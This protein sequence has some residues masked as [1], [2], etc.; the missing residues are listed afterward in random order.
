MTGVA[1]GSPIGR[2]GLLARR[3][4]A[5][6]RGSGRPRRPRCVRPVRHTAHG[7]GRDR[8]RRAALR[9]PFGGIKRSGYDANSRKSGIR[10]F[11][12]IQTVWIGPATG[13][14][15][16]LPAV[17]E[18]VPFGSAMASMLSLGPRGLAEALEEVGQYGVSKIAGALTPTAGHE[19]R[20]ALEA[21]D[22][23]RAPQWVG[24][25]RQDFDLLAIQPGL[26]IADTILAPLLAL[27]DSYAALLQAK[28]LSLD[29]PWLAVFVPRCPCATIRAGVRRISPI[30]T[31]GG[32]SSSSPSSPWAAPP[33]FACSATAG[34][35]R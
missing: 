30:A 11:V 28:A 19:L 17:E 16:D 8:L 9:L 10:E 29:E 31:T 25:V 20:K 14:T 26:G 22:F 33:N 7:A 35:R 4:G 23:E 1:S 12:N 27:A 32:S 24:E 6:P 15:S 2:L 3:P 13:P 21:L 18:T 5:R 34:A